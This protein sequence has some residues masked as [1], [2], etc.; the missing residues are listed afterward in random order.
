MS[1]EEL[2]PLRYAATCVACGAPLPPKTPARW[3]KA[4][5]AATCGRCLGIFDRGEAGASAARMGAGRREN[6][7]RRVRTAHPK[8]GNLILALSD[9]P[10]SVRSWEKG[11]IGERQLGAGLDFRK[12]PRLALLHDRRIPGSKTNIDHIVVGP[13]AIF[14]IDAKRYTGKVERRDHGWIFGRDWR[15]HVRGRDMTK[16]VEGMAR[17]VSAV[18]TALNDKPCLVIPVLC[19]IDA[20]WELFPNPLR[21]GDVRVMWPKA[22]YDFVQSDGPLTADAIARLERE[23]A[24]GLPPA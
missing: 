14:V 10:N 1:G 22:L 4:A 24:L 7:E 6:Y 5:R 3:D 8:L 20:N 2:R 13:A 18:E 11:A 23:I 15:L 9:T 19:F 12:S 21:F 17:Q 16:L